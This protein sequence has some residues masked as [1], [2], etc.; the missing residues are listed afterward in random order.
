M[1]E[2]AKGQYPSDDEMRQDLEQLNKLT[3]NIRI[4]TVEGTQAEIPG[5]QKSSACG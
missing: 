1:G 4:Y 3:D 5:W 2:P